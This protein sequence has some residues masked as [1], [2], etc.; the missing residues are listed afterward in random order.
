[1]RPS[2]YLP[3]IQTF[4]A[5]NFWKDAYAHQRGRL[6][7]RARVP[8][9]QIAALVDKKYGELPA[10]LRYEIETCGATRSELE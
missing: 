4:D 1:M 6:L 7:R 10:A 3:K 9:D 5:S 8:G 2:K